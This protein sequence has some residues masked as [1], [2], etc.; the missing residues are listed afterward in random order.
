MELQVT[1]LCCAFVSY[2]FVKI[3]CGMVDGDTFLFY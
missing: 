3:L 1:T 2:V